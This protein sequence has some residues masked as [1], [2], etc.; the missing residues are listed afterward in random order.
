M[1]RWYVDTGKGINIKRNYFK[2][3]EQAKSFAI[4]EIM[5][6]KELGIAMRIII[7]ILNGKFGG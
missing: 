6:E 3:E 1:G 4:K 7:K 2:T 5:Q